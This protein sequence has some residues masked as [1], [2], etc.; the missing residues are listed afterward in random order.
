MKLTEE[1]AKELIAA[2]DKLAEALK[3]PGLVAHYHYNTPPVWPQQP[4][5]PYQPVWCGGNIA[6]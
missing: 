6:V 3:S 4:A 1:T 5:Y 2:I